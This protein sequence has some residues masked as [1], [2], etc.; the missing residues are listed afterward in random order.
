MTALR[1]QTDQTGSKDVPSLDSEPCPVG[2]SIF[3]GGTFVDPPP[4]V[5]TITTV[6]GADQV[7]DRK[8]ADGGSDVYPGWMSAAVVPVRVVEGQI[9][10]LALIESNCKGQ[11]KLSPIK[12]KME[13]GET[14]RETAVREFREEICGA[15]DPIHTGDLDWSYA[16]Y[17][18]HSRMVHFAITLPDSA[19]H[20]DQFEPQGRTLRVL[21][22]PVAQC[23][24]VAQ[25][26]NAGL[27]FP[28]TSVQLKL[29][30]LGPSG[31][32]SHEIL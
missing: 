20:L 28:M 15:A 17:N 19:V 8:S 4:L 25:K 18:T 23:E 5:K 16:W 1:P 6:E 11:L 22:V 27:G 12:G 13:P 9:E 32:P 31:L 24:L 30:E 3:T 21:W 29:L 7:N 26:H 10:V 2:V 14:P